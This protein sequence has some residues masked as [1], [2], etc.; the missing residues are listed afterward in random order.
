MSVTSFIGFKGTELGAVKGMSRSEPVQFEKAG[1]RRRDEDEG[2][3]VG[4]SSSRNS[5]GRNSHK[6]SRYDD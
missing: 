6:K 5:G 1:D 4:G 3:E 2:E